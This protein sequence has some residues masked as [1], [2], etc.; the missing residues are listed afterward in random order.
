MIEEDFQTSEIL[1]VNPPALACCKGA[2][3][4]ECAQ[5]HAS[6]F[7]ST[8]LDKHI[9]SLITEN[10]LIIVEGVK[11]KKALNSFGITN[12]ITLNRPLFS[13]VEN[14]AEKTKEC[15]VLTDLDKEG[16]K[17]YSQLSKDLQRHGVKINNKFRNFLF[18]ETQLRQIEGLTSFVQRFLCPNK[19]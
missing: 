10:V 4:S 5:E 15:A 8:V 6:G 3:I 9:R 16:K 12:I 17:L 13:V 7:S 2:R 19:Y 11:D 14:V 1:C 18:K